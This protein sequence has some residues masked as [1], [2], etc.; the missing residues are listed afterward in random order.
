MR[1][2]IRG[3]EVCLSHGGRLPEVRAAAM[4]RLVRLCVPAVDVLDSLIEDHPACPSC[5]CEGDHGD[6]KLKVANS[7]LDRT[8]FGKT[9]H[10]IN[11]E[12]EPAEWARFLS[13]EQVDTIAQWIT[14]AQDRATAEDPRAPEAENAVH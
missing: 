1:F 5:K 2:A 3:G 6:L 10:V 12:K 11:E 14:E 7:V 4:D 9:L 8:G 13:S